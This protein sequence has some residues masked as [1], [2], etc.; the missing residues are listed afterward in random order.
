MATAPSATAVHPSADEW[1]R[2]RHIVR[3]ALVEDIG[4]GDVTSKPIIPATAHLRGEFLAKAG[5]VV[6]GLGVVAEVFRQVDERIV[7]K[8]LVRDG[9]PVE[10]GRIVARVE[11]VGPGILIAERVALNFLQRM[12]GIA[13]LTRQYV[14]AVAGTRARILDTRKTAPGLRVLD[15]LAVRLGGGDNHRAGLYD[16]VLIKDNH[17]EAAGSI[18]AAVRR[19]RQQGA[20]LKIEVEVESLAQLEEALELD[21]DRIMLDNM[22]PATMREAVR[23]VEDWAQSHGASRVELEAS[24]GITLDTAADVAATGVDLISV[25]ALTHSVRALDI[26]LEIRMPG[27]S[28]ARKAWLKDLDAYEAMSDEELV[29]EIARAQAALGESLAVLGHHYQRDEII[30]FADHTGDSLGLSQVAASLDKARYIV[31]CG[32]YF[33]AET[34]A[35]LCKPDQVVVQP[36]LEALCPMAQQANGREVAVAWKTLSSVWGDDIVPVTYQNSTA[37]VKAFVGEHGGAVCTSSNAGKLFTW[38]FKRKGHLLFVPDE[39][40]GTNTALAMGIP[41]EEIGIWTPVRPPDPRALASCRVVVWKGE[42][43]VHTGF[44]VADVE[45]ARQTHPDALIVV[46]PECRHEV[47]ALADALGSTTAIIRFVEKA[48]S[49]STVYVGTEWHLVNRLSQQYA[50][51][52]VLPLAQRSCRTMAMTR[53]PHLLE[54]LPALL[55]ESPRNVVRVS[56]DIARGARVDLERMLEAS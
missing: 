45:R 28:G 32:V 55:D 9:T 47:V 19:V 4:T 31:F 15:K 48:P 42:C 40:L 39:H 38:G 36:V 14:D 35:I 24:G 8:A 27:M 16:M 34:A 54:M 25:G 13:T 49:G 41:R 37:D 2:V 21:V 5:G 30:R 46:H 44:S 18:R 43:R 22:G 53:M 50:D 1:D 23:R 10:P 11:G 6:A 33:M 29:A 26:S 3:D 12:S 17:I 20:G 56:D 7:F 51:K 52:T